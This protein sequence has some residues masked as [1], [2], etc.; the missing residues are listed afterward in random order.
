MLRPWNAGRNMG[1]DEIVPA[2][3]GD[4]AIA[5]GEIDADFGLGGRR[6]F[7]VSVHGVVLPWSLAG[8]LRR[9]GG[10]GKG[11]APDGARFCPPSTPSS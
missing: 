3:E 5:G 6:G 2:I 4:E 8:S 7:D 10:R 1:E 9:I 11:D